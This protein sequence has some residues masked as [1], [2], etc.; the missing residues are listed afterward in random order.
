MFAPF[1]V[2]LMRGSLVAS[3]AIV[4]P[5]R[6]PVPPTRVGIAKQRS[7]ARTQRAADQCTL[8][9]TSQRADARTRATTDQRTFTGA[10]AAMPLVPVAIA[11]AVVAAPVAVLCACG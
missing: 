3:S 10:D 11:V 1:T 7:A 5:I 6:I 2:P 4:I 9:A 8:A